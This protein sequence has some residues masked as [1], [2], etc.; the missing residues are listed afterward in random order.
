MYS[1]PLPYWE[2]E[3]FKGHVSGSTSEITVEA[4]TSSCS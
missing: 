3:L 2:D 4:L 1:V